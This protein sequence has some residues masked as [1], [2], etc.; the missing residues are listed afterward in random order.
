MS[1][2]PRLPRGA[3]RAGGIATLTL[4]AIG[5]AAYVRGSRVD[6]EEKNPAS[7]AEGVRCQIL[8][9]G[10]GRTPV[11]CAAIVEAP[12]AVVA[13]TVRDYARFPEI[14]GSRALRLTLGEIAAEPGDVVHLVGRI[15]TPVRSWPLDVRVRHEDREGDV[16]VASWDEPRGA[17]IEN[18]GSWTVRPAAGGG[19]LL[20]YQLEVRAPG[21]PA[22]LV[23]DALLAEIPFPVR[24]VAEHA[25]AR[26]AEGGA[27]GAGV[28]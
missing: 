2:R 18:R 19:S 24:R 27:S 8:D 16:H 1:A 6:T 11:R 28:R 7:A 15:E 21:T 20:V 5:L 26:R 3:R 17:M 10:G 23:R 9:A 13:A 14:F 4:A 12:P 22:F 25:R